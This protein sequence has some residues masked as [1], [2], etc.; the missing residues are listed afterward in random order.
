MSNNSRLAPP[1]WPEELFGKIDREKARA[2]E[3]L[4]MTHCASCHNAWPYRW[5]APNKFGKSWVIVGLT[6]Q[7]YLGTDPGQFCEL[8]PFSITGQLGDNLP[9]E[10]FRLA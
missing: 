9:G 6:A 8:R 5:S 4:F 1:Q 3:G 10:G 7:S 2:G